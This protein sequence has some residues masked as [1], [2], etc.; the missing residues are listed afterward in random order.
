MQAKKLKEKNKEKHTELQRWWDTIKH[1]NIHV[2]GVP[3]G[4]VENTFEELVA[5]IIPNLM[6][7]HISKKLKKTQSTMNSVR[8]IPNHILVEVSNG[9]RQ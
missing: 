6:K 3:K 9:Q 4:E 1:T 5:K 8:P 2:I 7:T